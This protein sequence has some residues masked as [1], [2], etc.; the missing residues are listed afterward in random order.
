MYRVPYLV[1][2]PEANDLGQEGT[3]KASS[4]QLFVGPTQSRLVQALPHD[5][6]RELIHLYTQVG[7]P[8]SVRVHLG[9]EDERSLICLNCK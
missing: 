4:D 6:T 8:V 5:A 9:N 1:V 2:H 7:W 3:R